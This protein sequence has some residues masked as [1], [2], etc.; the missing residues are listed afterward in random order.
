MSA[1]V[2][3]ITPPP[4]DPALARAIAL[5]LDELAR[6]EQKPPSEWARAAVEEQLDSG[7]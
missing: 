6:D 5:A 3:Q 2:L 7:V 1:Q 4:H